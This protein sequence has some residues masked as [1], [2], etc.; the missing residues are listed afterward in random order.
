[1]NRIKRII[2][3]FTTTLVAC[4]LVLTFSLNMVAANFAGTITQFLCGFGID[5]D[6]EASV[7]A[8][9]EG[10]EIALKAAE[11]GITLLKNENGVL[12]V[13]TPKINV[14]GWA[15]CDYGFV[16]QGG[17]SGAGSDVGQVKLY[18][19]LRTAGIQINETLANAY[20][21]LSLRRVSYSSDV[22]QYCRIIEAPDDFLNNERISQAKSFSDTALIVISRRGAEGIDLP[23]VQ[24]DENGKVDETRIYSELSQAEEKMIDK[25]CSNF[26]KV[27]V[28]LNTANIM[29]TGFLDDDRIDAAM[30]IYMPGNHGASAVGEVLT[31]AINPSGR[32]VDTFAYDFTTAPTYVNSGIEGS[33]K[34][35]NYSQIKYIDY[36][37]SL[38]TGYY[39]YET[40][41][42]EGFWNSDYAK[43]KWNI[44]NG[45]EDVVQYPFG[46]GLSYTEFSWTLESVK[47]ANGGVITEDTVIEFNIFVENVGEKYSGQEVVE[48]YVELPYVKG[49]IEKP[50]LKLC[51]FAKT[52][53]L[54]PGVGQSLTITVRPYDIASYDCYDSNNN[55]FMGYE[56]DAGEYRFTFRK[57]VHTVKDMGNSTFT[58][59]VNGDGIRFSKDP[60]TE[61]SVENRFT[62]YQNQTSGAKSTISEPSLS[63]ESKAYSMDGTDAGC[64]V[65]F[66]TRSD[67]LG[68]FPETRVVR[69]VSDEFYKNSYLVNAPKVNSTDE[70]PKTSSKDTSYTL[71]DMLGLSYEDE[72]WDDL[73]SQLDVDTL[74][75]LCAKGGYQTVAIKSIG[76]PACID[77]DGCSGF[78]TVVTGSS[79]GYSINYPCA[80]LIASTW[81]WKVAYQIGLS[82][83]K[84]A[85]AAE[86]DGW[87]APGA[88]MH[89]SP[90]GGRNFEYYSEDPF[91]SGVICAYTIKGNM[92]EGLYSYI[93]HFAAN[94]SDVG[95]NGQYRWMTEQAFREIYLRPFE[96]A[97]KQGGTT[98]MMASVDRVGSVRASGSYALLTEVLRNEWGFRGS[99]I[100][101]YY[102]GGDVHDADENIRAGN[103]LMLNPDGTASLF[104]DRTSATAV[105]ALQKSAKN[106][107][108]TY[109]HTQYVKSTAK[110][111]PLTSA[112][113]TRSEVFAWWIILL[114]VI[115]VIIVLGSVFW[116][117]KIYKK[118]K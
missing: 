102:Q 101:D 31:G 65:K 75:L 35:T 49:E 79:T 50:S 29:E 95:R 82:V 92:E 107:L 112:I 46:Y 85:E 76:K 115:D 42:K 14:F 25:V 32:T 9:A 108:Y 90:L 41:D 69:S 117:Y 8:R 47:L 39:W 81:N 11:E 12:P 113:G 2:K 67:F 104:D 63:S 114:V 94:D 48:L 59:K 52:D 34:T 93:K 1:M 109:V 91:I 10:A 56:L 16:N 83:G 78:N 87:Y 68:T 55:G 15:G 74:A 45:Y 7:Q 86:I 38:Y 54:E 98:A 24:Y 3:I 77:L 71:N 26:D 110:G 60:D 53:L 116:L 70:M 27:I 19:G 105:I 37:E 5:Y 13:K 57:D 21:A 99:V 97:V 43:T 84:E 73:V 40:A 33:Q 111:L 62:N 44:K 96:I 64:D 72:K 20:N 80:T 100:T 17:G 66:L 106:I 118:R 23:T 89:R 36:A 51:G 6:S 88:N 22:S 58:Y 30:V 103:D 61:Y 18:A 28:L 4:I